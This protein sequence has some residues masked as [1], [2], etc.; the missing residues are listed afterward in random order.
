M[1]WIRF[2]I[3]IIIIM[4]IQAG[5]LSNLKIRPDLL[6][7]MLV[8]FAVHDT[9]TDAIISSFTIGLASN[10]IGS[11]PMGVGIISFGLTGTMLAFLQKSIS[12]RKTPF[13]AIAVFVAGIVC[14]ILIYFLSFIKAPA[15]PDFFR[16][17]MWASLYSAVVA[18]FLF[19]PAI[20]FMGLQTKR[21]KNY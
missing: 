1:R 20:W 2:G 15:A 11:Q 12:L 7:V 6:L 17:V 5:L 18:P 14:G 4:L 21:G 3:L 16:S 13:Q 9:A 19:P 8:F 10:L